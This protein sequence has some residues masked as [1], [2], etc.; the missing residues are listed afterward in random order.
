MIRLYLKIPES[1]MRF[2]IVD[3]FWFVYIPIDRMVKFYSLAQFP[4]GHHPAPSRALACPS[5]LYLLSMLLNYYLAFTYLSL[6]IV[7]RIIPF[8]FYT[9]LSCRYY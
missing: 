9:I 6:S 3:R 1:F 2:I 7:L 5:L 4:L 8:R